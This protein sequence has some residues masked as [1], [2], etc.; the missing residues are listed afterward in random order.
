[1]I[2]VSNG[3]C[4]FDNVLEHPISYREQ[5]LTLNFES[6]DTGVEMFHGIASAGALSSD[7]PTF[8]AQALPHLFSKT[9]FFRKSPLGQLEPNYVHC[10]SDMGEWTGILYLTPDPPPTD[11]TTFWRHRKTG[12]I[13]SINGF[14]GKEDWKETSSWEPWEHVA[15]KFNR[16]LL[17]PAPYFHSRAIFDNYGVDRDAR[18]IQVVFGMGELNRLS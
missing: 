5:A 1:M 2:E 16:L 18:L 7:L 6:V 12:L 9:T 14:D 10:D 8:I 11:G 3:L 4:V 17:F 13:E 15:A